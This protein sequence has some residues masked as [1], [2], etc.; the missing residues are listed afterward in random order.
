MATRATTTKASNASE[1]I[2][3]A[4]PTVALAMANNRSVTIAP[5][6]T[7]AAVRAVTGPPRQ[8]RHIGAFALGKIEPPQIN[9]PA[10]NP[11]KAYP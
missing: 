6:V 10:G 1:P 3:F 9:A 7:P 2:W 4:P 5:A 11:A 8:Y